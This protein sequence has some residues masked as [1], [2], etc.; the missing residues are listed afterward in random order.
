M[1]VIKEPKKWYIKLFTL[2]KT[3]SSRTFSDNTIIIPGH[4]E[5][6]K[7]EDVTKLKNT[8]SDLYTKT[9]IGLKNGLSHS[10]IS[11]SIE[12]TLNGDAT[13]KLNYIKSI[14]LELSKD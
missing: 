7:K 2:G 3:F 1:S 10:E 8:L 4:G 12:E 6:S 9:V 5:L 14:E 11:D 13:V